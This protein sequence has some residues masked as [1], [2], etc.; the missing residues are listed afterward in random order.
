MVIDWITGKISARVD[1]KIVGAVKQ[2]Q[3]WLGNKGTRAHTS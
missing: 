1:K 3:K 2:H